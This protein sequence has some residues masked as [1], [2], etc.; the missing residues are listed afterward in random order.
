MYSQDNK[1]IIRKEL[2]KFKN[3]W[4]DYNNR[5]IKKNLEE[6]KEIVFH[7]RIKTHG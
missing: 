7:F 2:K 3:I 1:I 4:N 5:I 6:E